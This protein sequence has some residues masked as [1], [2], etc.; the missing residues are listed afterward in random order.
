MLGIIKNLTYIFGLAPWGTHTAYTA[1]SQA[2]AEKS[3]PLA[4][5]TTG[6]SWDVLQSLALGPLFCSSHF[7]FHESAEVRAGTNH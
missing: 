6:D 4:L 7:L 3:A 2:G 1:E 5:G